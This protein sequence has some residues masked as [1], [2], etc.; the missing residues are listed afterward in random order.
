MTRYFQWML[1][2]LINRMD[3]DEAGAPVPPEGPQH[4]PSSTGSFQKKL[5]KFKFLSPRVPW[6]A[7][8]PRHG[9]R[10]RR[11]ALRFTIS[12]SSMKFCMAVFS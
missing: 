1:E 4:T 9:S 3:R 10:E 11:C 12:T 8:S 6:K 7:Q 5:E 2:A